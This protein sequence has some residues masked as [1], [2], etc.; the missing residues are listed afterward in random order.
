MWL[1]GVVDWGDES[2]RDDFEWGVAS[3]DGVGT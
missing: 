3:A 1:I 2:D